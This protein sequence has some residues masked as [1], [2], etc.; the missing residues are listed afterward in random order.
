MRRHQV[1]FW[2]GVSAF[3]ATILAIGAI[4]VLNPNDRLQFLSGV[5]VGII[6]GG[7]VYAK[8]RLDD[9]KSMRAGT[10]VVKDIDDKTIFSLE[11]DED[12]EILEDKA[13]LR[14]R[15]QRDRRKE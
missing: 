13:E 14:F 15:V 6:T 4:D 7:A 5:F 12:P 2:G 11:L 1:A 8:Q 9:E 3:F 10:I